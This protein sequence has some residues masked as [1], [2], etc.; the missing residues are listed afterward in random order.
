MG[1]FCAVSIALYAA[2][3]RAVCSSAAVLFIIPQCLL[4]AAATTAHPAALRQVK[5]FFN[6][7][8]TIDKQQKMLFS[9]TLSLIISYTKIQAFQ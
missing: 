1:F 4:S 9:L 6:F 7:Y 8:Y 2:F 5:S 3:V